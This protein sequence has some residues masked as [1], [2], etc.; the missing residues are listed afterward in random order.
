MIKAYLKDVVTLSDIG[1][2]YTLCSLPVS[3]LV[4]ENI[5]AKA[6]ASIYEIYFVF[7]SIWEFGGACDDVGESVLFRYL[8]YSLNEND[9]IFR[10]INF[11]Y[12]TTSQILQT[13]LESVVEKK[14]GKLYAPPA[15]NTCIYFIDDLNM[16]R[17]ILMEIN[18]Q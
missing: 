15:Q 14:A 2:E 11:N 13:F 8:L 7:A 10:A 16:P 5:S 17:L 12:Y 3:L 6:E 4:S 1:M 18:H 9:Y